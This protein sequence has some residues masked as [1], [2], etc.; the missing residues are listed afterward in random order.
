MGGGATPAGLTFL[1]SQNIRAFPTTC[2]TCSTT[3]EGVAPGLNP[4][5]QHESV[6]GVDYQLRKNLSFE[7][8]WDRRRLDHVIE[9]SAIFN[10]QVGETFVIVNPGQGI[11]KTFSSFYDFLYPQSPLV[12][13]AANPCPTSNTI[14]AARIR[15]CGIPA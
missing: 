15:R 10:P 3:E 14:P 13:N 6:F 4:Y 9:D 8:R 12:C 11:N 5:E 2:P 1:E 7:A